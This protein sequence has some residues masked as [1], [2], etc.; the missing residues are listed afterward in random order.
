MP[1]SCKPADV[2][3][4]ELIRMSWFGFQTHAGTTASCSNVGKP[5]CLISLDPM[6]RPSVVS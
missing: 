5:Y 2:R 1:R 4:S 3:F 6:I